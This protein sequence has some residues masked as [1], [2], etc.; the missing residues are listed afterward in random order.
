MKKISK[1]KELCYKIYLIKVQNKM[2]LN[3]QK[4]LCKKCLTIKKCNLFI[5]INDIVL[6]KEL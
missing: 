3:I 1:N 2:S 4:K 5:F 6:R